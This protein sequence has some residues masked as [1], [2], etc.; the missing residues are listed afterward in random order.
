M[1][2]GIR[3]KP[4]QEDVPNRQVEKQPGKKILS[5]DSN[6]HFASRPIQK[7][8]EEKMSADSDI[9]STTNRPSHY[10]ATDSKQTTPK[11]RARATLP[12]RP[13]QKQPE[14]KMSAD[15]DTFSSTNRPS[16]YFATDSKQTTPKVRATAPAMPSRPIQKQPEEKMSADSDTFSSTN[17]PSHYFATDSKQTTPKVRA[18]ATLP[19]RPI[20]KQHE[21]KMS[22][23][24]LGSIDSDFDSKETTL[25]AM[26]KGKRKRPRQKN[27]PRKKMSADSDSD[28]QASPKK[29]KTSSTSS[30]SSEF[31]CT[32]T[33]GS[34]YRPG[35]HGMSG[36]NDTFTSGSMNSRIQTASSTPLKKCPSVSATKRGKS[37]AT[38][39]SGGSQ[40][41]GK[42]SRSNKKKS[43]SGAFSGN[44]SGKPSSS[45][46]KHKSTPPPPEKDSAEKWELWN[47]IFEYSTSSEL[48]Q[49]ENAADVEKEFINTIDTDLCN[50]DSSPKQREK[51]LNKKKFK[52]IRERY[53]DTYSKFEIILLEN[54]KT[55]ACAFV[56]QDLCFGRD[57]IRRALRKSLE[58]NK[59]YQLRMNK[60]DH[61]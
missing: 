56:Q 48:Y 37:I 53:S 19:S 13:I 51:K 4:S 7:Q 32:S 36:Q 42:S 16:H 29:P 25:K 39:T 35:N 61:S 24:F 15:S 40:G 57:L 22:G 12:S 8:P 18:R 20:Q 44:S 58:T 54:R 28:L 60:S 31:H 43:T 6:S 1:E 59:V 14:E 10:F 55:V 52:F 27:K 38:P 11:V 21:E 2:T 47:P 3:I 45:S 5:S 50:E 34:S 30:T 26:N 41:K 23:I 17:R 49:C 9:V 46:K 33:P